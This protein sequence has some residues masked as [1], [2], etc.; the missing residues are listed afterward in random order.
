MD[1]RDFDELAGRIEGLA[2]LT[3]HLTASL[4]DSGHIDGPAMAEGLRRAFVLGEDAA[5]LMLTARRTAGELA[6]ALDD[7]RHW[8]RFRARIAGDGQAAA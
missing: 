8:R 4:E 6:K 5:P 1:D 2:R 3:L 7:A